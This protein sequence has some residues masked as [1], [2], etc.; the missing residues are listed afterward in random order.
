MHLH[1]SDKEAKLPTAKIKKIHR[2]KLQPPD[3]RSGPDVRRLKRQ[4]SSS[5]RTSGPDRT[6]GH[7]LQRADDRSLRTSGACQQNEN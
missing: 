1:P 3:D 4:P 6:T 5:Q 2:R 7:T